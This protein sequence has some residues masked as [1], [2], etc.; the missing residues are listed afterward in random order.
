[1]KICLLLIGDG[2]DDY[3]ERTI[4]SVQANL[5]LFS[6]LVEID[7]SDHQL[8]FAG[9]IHEGWERVLATGCDYVFHLEADFVFRAEIPVLAMIELLRHRP[10]L[11]QVALKRQ[12]VNPEEVAA[13]G[14][15]ELHRDDFHQRHDSGFVWTE[16]RRFFTT[17][18]SV[19][20]VTLCNQGW[21]QVAESEGIFSHR[22]FDEDPEA[23]SCFWGAKFDPPLIEHIGHVRAG[24]SY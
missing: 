11:V 21:P 15:V 13:G 6:R 2:R 5:P 22:L 23:A 12:P 17:N 16:H 19:Y 1:M 24:H 9:A 10:Y 18:P 20:P 7:D 3:R 8:G 14:I 4:E